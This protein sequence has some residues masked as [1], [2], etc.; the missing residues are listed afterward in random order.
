MVVKKFLVVCPDIVFAQILLRS[1]KGLEGVEILREFSFN[2]GIKAIENKPPDLVITQIDCRD[3]G[4]FLPFIAK[5]EELE[6]PSVV[7]V[8]NCLNPRLP[9]IPGR[10]VV[11]QWLG[12]GLIDK[13][14]DAA[15][16]FMGL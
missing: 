11:L 9:D 15:K 5:L 8:C 14:E 3:E 1:V 16:K 13:I 7:V 6:I 12:C 4:R 2:D 10:R